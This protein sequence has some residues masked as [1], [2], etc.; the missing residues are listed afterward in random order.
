MWEA[1]TGELGETVGLDQLP[2][3]PVGV[4]V[5]RRSLCPSSWSG[6]GASGT[7]AVGPATG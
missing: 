5:M 4:R 3:R 1:A 6:A 7:R 2:G